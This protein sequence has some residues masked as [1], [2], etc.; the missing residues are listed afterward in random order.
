MRERKKKIPIG[1]ED[2]KKIVDRDYYYVDKTLLIRDLLDQGGAVN[3]FTRPRRFGK[4]L[5][6]SMLRTYFEKETDLSG[7]V[8]DNSRYFDGTAIAGAGQ[9]YR[10][11]MGRYPVVSLSLKGAK[12]PQFDMAYVSLAEEIAREFKR[13]RYVLSTDL[14]VEEDKEKYRQIM[15]GRAPQIVCAGALAF[16]TECLRSYHGERVIVLMDEYDVPLENAFFRGF[17]GQMA[18]FIRSLFESVLKTNDNLE[19]A[20]ITGCLRIS[21]ESIFTGLN[22]LSIFSVLT[23][24]YAEYFGFTPGE[25]QKMLA[26]YGLSDRMDE[27]RCWYDG[28]LFGNQE[29][30]NPW[31]VI[32]YVGNALADPEAFPRPYWSNTSSNSIVRQLVE[33]ADDGVKGELEELVAGR[34]IEKPVHEDVTYEDVYKT[35]DNLWNFLFFTGYLRR[36]GQR[37]AEGTVYLTLVIPNEEVRYVYRNTIREWF[38]QR[39]KEAD[40]APLQEAICDGDSGALETALRTWLL[41]G[42]SYHDNQ[43]AFYHG[44]VLGLLQP[45][46]GHVVRSNREAGEGRPDI[47]VVPFD[48]KRPALILELKKADSYGQMEEQCRRALEQIRSKNYLEE[49]RQEGYREFFC[50]GICFCRKNCRVLVERAGS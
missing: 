30:C 34:A 1:I 49:L 14:I 20:V 26:D 19:F 9:E 50:Y 29:V 22:N 43:E 46:P 16:L 37:L 25:T 11:H 7:G 4:T 2:Y 45:F 13:H 31:S 40:K 36:A 24:N 41:K 3:L 18:D 15:G 10:A 39:L 21:R 33:R 27:V 35:Q 17:Y 44:Y 5:S 6:L 12:Q 8:T 28:Y 48:L 23:S 38:S 42:I 47:Q 32:N